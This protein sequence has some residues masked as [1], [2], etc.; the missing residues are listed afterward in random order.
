MSRYSTMDR[1]QITYNPPY[2][3]SSTNKNN[4]IIELL[5][6]YKKGLT[7]RK[8]N[9]DDDYIKFLRFSQV[10]VEKADKGVIGFITNNSF[11]DGITHR[12]I[13]KSLVN[14]FD[15]IY[16]INLHGNIMAHEKCSDGSK[17]ENVFDITQGVSIFLGVRTNSKEPTSIYYCDLMGVRN[18]KYKWLYDHNMDQVDW[19]K[20]EPDDEMCMFIPVDSSNKSAYN[21]GFSVVDVFELFNSGIQTK[22]DELSVKDTIS[23][24]EE[25]VQ[26]FIDKDV[27]TLKKIY[28]FKKDSS[29]WCFSKAKL[30]VIKKDYS[31]TPYYYRPFD[32]KYT[33]YTGR[34]GG[35]I[36]RSREIVMKHMINHTDNY[37]LCLMKQFF[38]DVI[39]NHV[40]ISNIPIDERTM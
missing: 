14:T 1:V 12:Q 3:V 9:L 21:D 31:I 16:I 27:D 36:G 20:I 30:D 39:Y 18:H 35:F 32:F 37:S 22:C 6:E 10:V 8:L 40:F 29:G 38:Q 15:K 24:L 26:N 17:D 4:W 11:V 28:Y 34:S 7:E 13:R 5:Q 23:D 19:K 33:V 2:N 25:V